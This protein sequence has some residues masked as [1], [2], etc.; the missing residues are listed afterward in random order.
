M[1]WTADARRRFLA[2]LPAD[3]REFVVRLLG[4]Q[5][6]RE[7]IARALHAYSLAR[8]LALQP[9]AAG[10]PDPA[11][12]A[13][14]ALGSGDDAKAM[15]LAHRLKAG[16]LV[17]RFPRH[18]WTQDEMLWFL[19]EFPAPR[20]GQPFSLRRLT[21]V[22]FLGQCLRTNPDLTWPFLMTVWNNYALSIKRP[23]WRTKSWRNLRTAYI[24]TEKR[25]RESAVSYYKANGSRLRRLKEL[26]R[27]LGH[28]WQETTF[29]GEEEGRQ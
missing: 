21:V 6:G 28:P 23:S 22:D 7:E 26:R 1:E 2:S 25:L 16:F 20:R 29:E 8:S 27:S 5:A 17:R 14:R 11:L 10:A 9:Q 12:S 19:P 4:G 24:L 3:Q 15:D 13:R 18:E